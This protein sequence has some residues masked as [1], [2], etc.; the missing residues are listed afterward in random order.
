MQLLESQ[1]S[2]DQM[3]CFVGPEGMPGIEGPTG[4]PGPRGRKGR[5][6]VSVA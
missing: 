1:Y 5:D 4:P 6:G 3:L 2:G